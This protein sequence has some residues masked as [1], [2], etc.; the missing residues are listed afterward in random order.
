ML[1]LLQKVTFATAARTE[2]VFVVAEPPYMA[3]LQP[4]I[5]F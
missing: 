1:G 4:R 3:V 2:S 5:Y